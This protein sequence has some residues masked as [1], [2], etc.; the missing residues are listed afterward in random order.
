MFKGQSSFHRGFTPGYRIP[1]KAVLLAIAG[2]VGITTGLLSASPKLERVGDRFLLDGRPFKPWGVRVASASQLEKETGR[3]LSKLLI[4]NLPEYKHH[5]INAVT[6]FYQGSSGTY[7]DPFSPDGTKIEPAHQAR[8]ESIIRACADL[9]MVVVVG[10]FYQRTMADGHKLK[11][12]GPAASREAVRTVA[13]ALKPYRNVII[14]IANE[15][16]SGYYSKCSFI[17]EFDLREP[18]L[19]GELCRLVKSVDPDR[20]V[21]AGGY[22]HDKN[23]IIGRSPD[24]DVLL[25]DTLGKQDSGELYDRFV[26]A[27]VTG[28]PI[29]NVE[30]YGAWTAGFPDA[31]KPPG[32]FVAAKEVFLRDIQAAAE[33]PGLSVFLHSNAWF[34]GVGDGATNRYDLG[35]RGTAEDPGVRWYFEAVRSRSQVSGN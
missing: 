9:D 13:T 28:K 20:L 34:Q 18:A 23:E 5:G 14:N 21:G 33:R 24:V 8:M 25:F 4:E 26:K 22:D 12:T 16:N 19:L 29:V 32:N 17:K 11:L 35:G 30:L 3:D 31:L 1:A 27:G 7:D 15:Q 2:L 6:V 10:I